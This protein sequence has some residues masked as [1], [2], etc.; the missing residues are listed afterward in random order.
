MECRLSFAGVSLHLVSPQCFQMSPGLERFLTERE[1]AQRS[2]HL[3]FM[4]PPAG[5]TSLPYVGDDFFRRYYT[6]GRN[7]RIEMK[8]A[9]GRPSA[10]LFCEKGALRYEIY[11]YV[12]QGITGWISL[13]PMPWLLYP[14]GVFFLH[15]S[16]VEVGGKALVFTGPS[17]VGKT[18]Q[19]A[20]WSACGGGII[21]G[22][23]RVLLRRGEGRWQTYGYFEDGDSPVCDPTPL[24]LAALVLPEHAT[25]NAV[26]R[27]APA[28]AVAGLMSQMM[29]E[30][31]DSAMQQAVLEAVLE[32]VQQC[33]VYRLRC[34]AEA[35]AVT[36]LMKKLKQDGVIPWA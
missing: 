11:Q 12:G 25:E 35:G 4:A 34:R 23:D 33:P 28:K 6:D 27:M 19:A 16:R 31:W 20:L 9:G 15:A 7:T 1:E 36:C 22:N 17:G 13:L 30:T 32:L 18:T 26:T 21:R 24:P 14:K 5:Q 2:L 10:A 8:G 3:E 29:A